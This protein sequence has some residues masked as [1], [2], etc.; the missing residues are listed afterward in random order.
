MREPC[1]LPLVALR[2][3]ETCPRCGRPAR[4]HRGHPSYQETTMIE[5]NEPT[6]EQIEKRIAQL[7]ALVSLPEHAV[8]WDTDLAV[9]RMAL[10]T[11]DAEEDLDRARK[12]HASFPGSPLASEVI[13]GQ[14]RRL[15]EMEAQL[16][17]MTER[18]EKAE[19]LAAA[20]RVVA[21]H[22]VAD[23]IV[24]S[25]ER[26]TRI[27]WIDHATGDYEERSVDIPMD[28]LAVGSA[29]GA[30]LR[31]VGMWTLEQRAERAECERGATSAALN[32]L[33]SGLRGLRDALGDF[34]LVG[35]KWTDAVKR[36]RAKLS[37]A[38]RRLAEVGRELSIKDAH[39]AEMR[40]ALGEQHAKLSNMHRRAQLAENPTTHTRCEATFQRK[41]AEWWRG[42]ANRLGWTPDYPE[43]RE[44]RTSDARL[45]CES[46]S[47][48]LL[49]TW[50]RRVMMREK[51]RDKG[52]P[53]E[54]VEE[55]IVMARHE[56]SEARWAISG[57]APTDD[58]LAELGDAA[59]II[60][61]AM[62]EI[63]KRR[64][65]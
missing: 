10:R 23:A 17:A 47:L 30:F 15:E 49:S 63:E 43:L 34:T 20:L 4:E 55:L 32:D 29:V 39:I 3:D 26:A 16:A 13:D 28:D 52:V 11:L 58:I 35:E 5:T 9:Y 50:A 36:L 41:R 19:R 42:E 56:L 62:R 64:T 31:M 48:L 44:E 7:E 40:R 46:S 51:N 54:S 53:S 18:A 61:F 59:A 6:R 1:P 24:K 8:G 14:A 12:L 21:E 25:R 60:G 27:G 33:A 65:A 45:D 37:D 57:S 2:G 22:E 38:E